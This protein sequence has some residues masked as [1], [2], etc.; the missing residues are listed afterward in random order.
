[1]KIYIQG[2]NHTKKYF[3]GKELISLCRLL[4][5]QYP[6]ENI[7]IQVKCKLYWDWYAF[8]FLKQMPKN[9][10]ITTKRRNKILSFK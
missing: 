6:K 10:K 3:G 8:K 7:I 1:M 5:K 2:S 9:V 4:S